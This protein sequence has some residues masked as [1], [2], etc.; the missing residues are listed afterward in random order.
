MKLRKFIA[1]MA[2]CVLLCGMLPLSVTAAID[3]NP[4]KNGDFE[5]GTT[6]HWQVLSAGVS[7]SADAA[8]TGEYGC[9]LTGNGGWNDLLSQTFTV[10]PGY[11]YSLNFWYKADPMGVSWYLLDGGENGTRLHRGWAGNTQWS[12]VTVYF[13]PTTDTVCLLYRCSG[14]HVA[15]YV[16][17]DDVS[18]TLQPCANHTYDNDCDAVCNIC[19]TVRQVPDHVYDHDCDVFCNVCGFE[20][21][22][23]GNHT[24]DYPCATQCSYCGAPRESLGAHTYSDICD[25]SCNF[26]GEIRE[27]EHDYDHRCDPDC[28][29]CGAVRVVEHLYDYVCDPDCNACGEVRQVVHTYDNSL[30]TDCNV[31]GHTRTENHCLSFGGAGISY[32]VNGIAFRFHLNAE[33]TQI[34]PDQSYIGRSATVHRYD[35]GNGYKLIR[36]GA[37]MSNEKNPTLDLEHLTTRTIDVK[38][39]YLCKVTAEKLSFA[40]RIINIPPQGHNTTIYARPYYVYSDGK[41]EI[42]VYGDAFTQT[43]AGLE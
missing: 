23:S 26:C 20:R 38:A 34:N 18:V 29:A 39:A 32:D 40:V 31:C 35:D 37:V 11:T 1:L 8:Y 2:V 42:V 10:L 28:N 13:T 19:D 30:D 16:Y 5:D 6:D 25:P 7:V 22:A 36:V 14:S 9:L 43:F 21:P 12:K 24:Y 27:P 17:L 3:K 41:E 33:G 15:E 4:L